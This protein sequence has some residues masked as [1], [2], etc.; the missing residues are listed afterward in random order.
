M[1]DTIQI[2]E[3]TPVNMGGLNVIQT[4][5][6]LYNSLIQE[7]LYTP[8]RKR[9]INMKSSEASKFTCRKCGSHELI[10][11]HIWNIQAGNESENWREWGPLKNDHH[12]QYEF[13]EKIEKNADDEVQ[14]GDFSDFEE[15]D[16]DSEPEDYEVHETQT[17]RDSS[18]FFVNCGNCDREIEFGWS[19]PDQRGLIFP[20]EFSD[21]PSSEVWPDLKYTNSWAQ[22]SLLQKN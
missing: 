16:S 4:R 17:S 7:Y 18:E 10:V 21:F 15:D 11:I 14:R 5:L 6:R 19:K 8:F 3:H 9:S 22:Q 12:W 20:V 13:K 2:L 1:K